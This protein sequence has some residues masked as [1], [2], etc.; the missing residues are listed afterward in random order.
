M[1]VLYEAIITTGDD[2]RFF[3]GRKLTGASLLFWLNKWLIILC[4][5]FSLTTN[6]HLSDAVWTSSYPV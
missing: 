1:L 4:Y 3:W 2:I 5:A 6:L